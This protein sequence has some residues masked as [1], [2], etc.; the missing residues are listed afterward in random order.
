MSETLKRCSVA[1]VLL[2]AF[3][4]VGRAQNPA[5]NPPPPPQEQPAGQEILTSGP[6]HEA[7]A[8]PVVY[9]PKPG[10]VIPKQPP[11]PIKE[12]PPD[13]KPDGANVQWIPGYWAWDDQRNDYLWVSGVWRDIPPGQQWVPGYWNQVDSGSQWVPGAWMPVQAT[14]TDQTQYLPEPPPS[15]ENG[16]NQPS[17]GEGAVWTPGCWMWDNSQYAWRPGFWVTP[18][19][20]WMWVPA[21]YTWTPGGYLYVAGYW[22]RPLA[23]RGQL[24]APVSYSQPLYNQPNYV[25]QPTIG[26]SAAGM[27]NSL[28]VR[29]SYG[30]YYYGDYYAP[31]YFGAGIYPAFA[32]HQT[33]YGYDPLF[34]YYSANYG[35]SNP[36]WGSQSRDAYLYRRDHADARPPGTYQQM[37]QLNGSQNSTISNASVIN[38]NAHSLA[39][40]TPINT[41]AKAATGSDGTLRFAHIAPE[42]Q[43]RFAQ[44]AQQ[45]QQFGH[46]RTQREATAL[47]GRPASEAAM[48]RPFQMPRSPI[49]SAQGA[50]PRSEGNSG[51]PEAARPESA[52]ARPRAAEARPV[53]PPRTETPAAAPRPG[54]PG[55]PPGN[56]LAANHT[57]PPTPVHPGL[58]RSVQPRNLPANTNRPEPHP[59]LQPHPAGGPPR[60]TAAQAHPAP[61]AEPRAQVPA[62]PA[63]RA[64]AAPPAPRGEPGKVERK[65]R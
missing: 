14:Q 23:N 63:T 2:T 35:K 49:A 34:A 47:K 52:P 11:P 44:Q 9:D 15:Q 13:Q 21:Q 58:D 22:D 61:G 48:A 45:V 19:D 3:A 8:Q 57:P 65:P 33:K 16:P 25:Y 55:Q 27:L 31:N 28:F 5:A 59:D 6:M 18:Q 41:I 50:P 20:G 56:Q 10:P 7:F 62:T 1:L 32:Y 51:R 12:M 37:M 30:S 17:P 46:D 26:L 43:Q 64:P 53:T 42:E 40:A 38:N 29:P 24:F 39:Y 36:N 60:A 4:A 54:N